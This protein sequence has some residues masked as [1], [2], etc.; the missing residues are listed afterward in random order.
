MTL[1]HVQGQLSGERVIRNQR[2]MAHTVR[3]KPGVLKSALLNPYDNCTEYVQVV[4]KDIPPHSSACLGFKKGVGTREVVWVQVE[5]HHAC[6]IDH[7]P[8]L[9]YVYV[10]CHW[11][12]EF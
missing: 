10:S 9:V 5:T 6:G 1:I 11:Y 4:I 7:F 3:Y 12:V 8:N 2:L